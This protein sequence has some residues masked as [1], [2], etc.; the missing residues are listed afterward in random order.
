VP[1][2]EDRVVTKAHDRTETTMAGDRAR[3]IF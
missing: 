2:R 1:D 3:Y